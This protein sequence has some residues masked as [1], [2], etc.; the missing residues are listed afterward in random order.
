MIT[1]ELKKSAELV[2]GGFITGAANKF[3]LT[4]VGQLR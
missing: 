4:P 1:T 2:K 3:W